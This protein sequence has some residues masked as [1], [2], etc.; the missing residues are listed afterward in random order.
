MK[1][2]IGKEQINPS[3]PENITDEDLILIHRQCEIQN[4]TSP[5][6]IQGFTLAYSEA[7]KMAEDQ[8]KLSLLKAEELETLIMK[9]A[10]T[11]EPRNQ[12][13]FRM[14][15]ATFANASSAL[16]AVKIPRAIQNFCQAYQSFLEDPTEDER[17]NT[18]SLYKEFEEIHPFEDGNGRLGDLLWKLLESRKN[19]KWPMQ[20]PPDVFGE[21]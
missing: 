20:L 2:F 16:E 6:Q 15:P 21:K 19:S 8:E 4:A 10:T 13:G 5:E 9:W 1:E 7:K 12:K 3:R 17:M 18:T 14:V 11:I